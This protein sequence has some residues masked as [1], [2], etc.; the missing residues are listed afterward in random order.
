MIRFAVRKPAQNAQSIATSGTQMLG[1]NP[2]NS[3]LVST[4]LSAY[5]LDIANLKRVILE[6]TLRQI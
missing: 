6:S 4:F 1:F 2:T 5:I 3:T